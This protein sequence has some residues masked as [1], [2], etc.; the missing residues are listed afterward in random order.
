MQKGIINEQDHM[1]ILK[2]RDKF[3][4]NDYNVSFREQISIVVI[5]PLPFIT[6]FNNKL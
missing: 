3:V 5:F 2:K 6:I 4:S 1:W